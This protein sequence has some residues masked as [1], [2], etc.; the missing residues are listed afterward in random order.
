MKDGANH[1]WGKINIIF[2]LRVCLEQH[3]FIANMQIYISSKKE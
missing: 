3:G 1:S 2:A